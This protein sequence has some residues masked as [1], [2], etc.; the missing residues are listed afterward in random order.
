MLTNTDVNRRNFI[1]AAA[2]G[3]VAA[4]SIP[5]IVE[6]ALPSTLLGKKTSSKKVM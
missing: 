4:I 1:K 6:A 5:Q 3:T 2:I